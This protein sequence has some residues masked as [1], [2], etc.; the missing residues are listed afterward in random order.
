MELP[1]P[2]M[3][4]QV[5]AENAVK[6]GIYR[7][8]GKGYIGIRIKGTDDNLSI[9]VTDNGVGRAKA[10]E[11]SKES[12]GLGLKMIRQYMELFGKYKKFN[13]NFSITD[14]HADNGQPSGTRVDVTI[15]VIG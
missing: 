5:F 1:V 7:K 4:I 14:L 12:T 15:N 10:A 3:I 11:Y 2:K 8:E 6:H 13:I 9:T